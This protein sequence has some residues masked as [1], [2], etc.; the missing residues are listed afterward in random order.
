MQYETPGKHPATCL[1][2]PFHCHLN[3]HLYITPC[4]L[5][6]GNFP[7]TT[8]LCH[9][10]CAPGCG[11]SEWL[12][13]FTWLPTL[14][15]RC[16]EAVFHRPLPLRLTPPD[17]VKR[18]I[19]KT[20]STL[21]DLDMYLARSSVFRS[22]PFLWEPWK[23]QAYLMAPVHTLS[24][25]FNVLMVR[26][27]HIVNCISCQCPWSKMLSILAGIRQCKDKV[28]HTMLLFV[29]SNAFLFEFN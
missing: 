23:M 27:E 5:M 12:G 25:V 9:V 21:T 8:C 14:L 6:S 2:S 11:L 22:L 19:S 4:Y 28:F 3:T 24:V 29:F 13:W 18:P 16:Q 15:K 26:L 10:S 20:Q 7:K 17:A 1:L